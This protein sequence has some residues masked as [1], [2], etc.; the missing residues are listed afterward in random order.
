MQESLSAPQWMG[1]MRFFGRNAH[2]LTGGGALDYF[3]TATGKGKKKGQANQ[4]PPA[5]ELSEEEQ[6]KRWQEATA[7]EAQRQ[8]EEATR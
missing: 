8:A 2:L 6:Y 1:I 7:R 4:P 5:E 3:G